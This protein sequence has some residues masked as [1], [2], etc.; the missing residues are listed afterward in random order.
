MIGVKREMYIG[1]VADEF[2]EK[3]LFVAVESVDDEAQQLVDLGLESKRLRVRH[4]RR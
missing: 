2:T 1:R 4:C 3:D